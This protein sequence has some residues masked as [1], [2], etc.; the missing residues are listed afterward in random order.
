MPVGALGR[1]TSLASIAQL[2]PIEKGQIFNTAVG[3][4]A[5]FFAAA[6]LPTNTP[7]TFRI[8]VALNAAGLL[9]VRRTE[10]GV[11]VDEYLNSGNAL[12]ANAAYM[13]DILVRIGQTINLRH[14]VGGTILCC[15]VEEVPGVIC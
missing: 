3:A 6:L 14:S 9:Y 11:T 1:I 7:T 4:A 10:G 5:D 13:F 2:T 15:I 8:Y 12:N